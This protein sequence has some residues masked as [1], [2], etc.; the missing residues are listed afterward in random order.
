M[1]Q[2]MGVTINPA[3]IQVVKNMASVIVTATLPPYGQP[4]SRLD[5]HVAAIGDATN[6]QGGML[7]LTPLKAADGRVYA[8]TQGSVVTGGFSAGGGAIHSPSIIQR[9]AGFLME[10]LLNWPPVRSSR[11]GA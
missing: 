1:L 7:V 9:P 5:A 3:A 10:A 4:G 2:R 6:L 11:L 8:V